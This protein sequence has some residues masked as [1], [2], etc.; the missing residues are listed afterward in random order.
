MAVV[1]P[2]QMVARW[3]AEVASDKCAQR[4]LLLVVFLVLLALAAL[5]LVGA[6]REKQV[7]AVWV[8]VPE[9]G[10]PE[11]VLPEVLGGE[12]AEKHKLG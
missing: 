12:K 2:E 9:A 4:V 10:K 1:T 7:V 8:V 6:G 5:G 3:V 11:F